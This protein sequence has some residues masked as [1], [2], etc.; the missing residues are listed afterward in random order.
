MKTTSYK[1]A[2]FK[3]QAIDFLYRHK[4]KIYICVFCLDSL[5]T[6]RQFW[7]ITFISM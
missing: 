6:G 5:S 1:F 4:V 7:N 3:Y 2:G